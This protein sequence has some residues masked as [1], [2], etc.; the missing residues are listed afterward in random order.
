MHIPRAG[1]LIWYYFICKREVWLMARSIVPEQ[2]H[3]LVAMG[4]WIE[5][6]TYQRSRK[7]INL[8]HVVIDVMNVE[9]G[10]ILVGEVKKSSRYVK[11]ATM[12]LAYYLFVLKQKGIHA[13]GVLLFPK[14]RKRL[15]VVLDERLEQE[16]L[17]VL[18]DIQAIIRK[19]VPPPPVPCR[20]CKKCA[21]AEFC[22]S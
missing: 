14:E 12:Q 15:Q 13:E 16:L 19:E 17:A 18:R 10:K 3:D 1:T 21:Y 22:W 5:E 6:T 20:F 4:R 8:E 7:R 2:D 11:S 9:K